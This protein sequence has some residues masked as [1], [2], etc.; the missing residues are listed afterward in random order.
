MAPAALSPFDGQPFLTG[1]E[2]GRKWKQGGGEGAR[3]V[4]DVDGTRR[5]RAVPWTY[6]FS[7]YYAYVNDVSVVSF[8]PFLSGRVVFFSLFCA[9]DFLCLVLL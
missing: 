1:E 3:E 5:R 2:Q 8:I 7:L 6:V 4:M 9:L